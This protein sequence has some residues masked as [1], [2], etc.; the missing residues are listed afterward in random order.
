[1]LGASGPGS[2]MLNSSNMLSAEWVPY[3]LMGRIPVM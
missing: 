1:M 3:F 2:T